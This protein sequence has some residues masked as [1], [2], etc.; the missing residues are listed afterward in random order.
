MV[1]NDFRDE[2][3]ACRQEHK[4]LEERELWI[5][6]LE[7]L[8]VQFVLKP[9]ADFEDDWEKRYLTRIFSSYRFIYSK[10]IF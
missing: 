4:E 7:F 2:L 9:P 8:V 10:K 3:L 1:L 6:F 5:W